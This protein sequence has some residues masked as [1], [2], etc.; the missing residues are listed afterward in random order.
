MR[1]ATRSS[2]F[3]VPTVDDV[4]D[5]E[6]LTLPPA[7]A[8]PPR[9]PLP[10]VAS[11]VPVVGAA[12]LWLVT[13]SI[14][15]LWLAAL[16]PLIAVATM[17]DAARSARR[18]RRRHH[19]DAARARD[20]A[21]RAVTARHD[22]ERRRAW[23][24]HPDVSSFLSREG[25]IWRSTPGR[26]DMLV[27]G[28]GEMPSAVRISGGEG[29]PD[30]AALR[31]R[32]M[33]LPH[34]PVVVPAAQGVVV[35]GGEI[36]GAAVQR[37]LVLQ[38]CMAAPPGEL[39][40]AGALGDEL[41]WAE[42]LPHCAVGAPRRMALV[43][44]GETVPADADL[45]IVRRAPG[46]PLPPR[47]T[48]I[49]TVRSPDSATMEHG[50]ETLQVR[51]EAVAL[52]Q[53]AAVASELAERAERAL[54]IRARRGGPI[55]LGPLVSA[56]AEAR[57]GGLSAVIGLA[58]HDPAI[59]DLVAD[60]PHAVVAG[61]TGSG[62]SELLITWILSLCGTHSTSEVTFL[63]ADFKG[64]TAFDALAAVPHVTGVI[65][66]L[67]GAGARRAIE[68]LRAEVRRREAAIAGAG[69]RDI[70]DPRVSL[71]RLVI[72]VD[73]FA[74]LLGDHPELHAVFADVA[75]RGRALGVHLVLGTQR[76]SGVIRDS[77]LANCPLRISLRVTDAADSR[78]VLG[79]DDAALL[80]G[81]P[82]GRGFAFLRGAGDATPRPVRIA[83]SD[84]ADVA[85]AAARAGDGA[86]RRPWLPALPRRIPLDDLRARAAGVDEILLGLVDEPQRQ[87]QRVVGL[88]RADRALLVLGGPGS[89][90]SSTLDLVESQ[91]PG[92]I[93][94]PT[95]PEAMWDAV[96]ALA[97]VPPPAGTVVCID[98]LDAVPARLP[99]DHAQVVLERLEEIL[100]RAGAD[101]VLVIA[102]AHRIP[103][104]VSRLAELFPRRLQLSFPTR[105]EHIAAGG[106]PAAFDGDAPPGRGT[107]DELAIQVGI[108]PPVPPAEQRRAPQWHPTAQ[109]TGFVTRRSP[110]ARA[111][112]ADWEGRGIRTVSVDGYAADASI[113]AEGQV[114]IVGEPDD[115]Q[116]HW[117]LLADARGDHD[118]V[119]DSSCAAEF[120]LLTGSRALP[121][122]CEPG[123]G[124]AWLVARGAEAVRIVLPS[125]QV[126]PIRHPR[127][128]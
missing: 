89:G 70:L 92:A 37:A 126:R 53:A 121:P 54:G 105:S 69:A 61:V 49:L 22:A 90:A 124:R 60:G 9:P 47:C 25:E 97:A 123:R 106:D 24:R 28:E 122:Y 87:L 101:G 108:A 8:A 18:D 34:A 96:A 110:A 79:T 33:T 80:P 44:P 21:R 95:D 112:L 50:G 99:P 119:V 1:S 16:G 78:T 76:A 19:A 125:A 86:P 111:A 63:L 31:A 41:A 81:G 27:I 52:D 102:S 11:V 103:G 120:R 4:L 59:V 17:A 68:S 40:I 109:L 20:E 36:L 62:K 51:V 74:A 23:A 3:S 84:E 10:V 100:R 114:V 6:P 77:L 46:E 116:R 72:V 83:L 26:T 7:W 29:D 5:A 39:S 75:A 14:L 38:L 66:D 2:A 107:F 104:A 128:P 12:G 48:T 65:T 118:L 43:G 71:P 115:W 56:Q 88:R 15:S 113:V 32:A 85:V 93:R 57:P 58:G 127:H 45:A 82:E 98:D 30:A 42:R 91:A 35:V 13:G 117:R 94:I 73:E 55:A 64:G 67:D